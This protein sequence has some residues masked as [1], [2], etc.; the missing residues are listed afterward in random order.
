MKMKITVLILVLFT[1]LLVSQELQD[2]RIIKVIDS[3]L[4]LT[5][6][7]KFVKLANIQTPSLNSK[8]SLLAK[9]IIRYSQNHM[10]NKPL[11]CQQL[12]NPDN[13]TLNIVLIEKF[14]FN[15]FNFNLEFL[16]CGYGYYEKSKAAKSNPD[17]LQTELKAKQKHKGIWASKEEKHKRDTLLSH[18]LTSGIFF[19][20]NH[21]VK[22]YWNISYNLYKN[23]KRFQLSIIPDDDVF[24]LSSKIYLRRK[25]VSINPGLFI[26]QDTKTNRSFLLPTIGLDVGILDKIYLYF[27]SIS[28]TIPS[29]LNFGLSFKFNNPYNKLSLGYFSFY[30]NTAIFTKIRIMPVKPIIFDAQAVHN[31]KNNKSL[32]FLGAGIVFDNIKN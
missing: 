32:F 24:L 14:P 19:S 25:Y 13:D 17:Y 1:S 3:N 20:S 16:R 2:I 15:E 26:A 27:D 18:V 28:L 4:F 12:S 8:D 10:L 11:K 23:S 6:T 5:D 22:K 21:D 30:K 9:E 7:N 31:F 29:I